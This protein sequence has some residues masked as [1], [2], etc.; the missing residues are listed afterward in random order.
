M[1]YSVREMYHMKQTPEL[2]TK[3]EIAARKM[4]IKPK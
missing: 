4:I 3:E 1:M 2:K